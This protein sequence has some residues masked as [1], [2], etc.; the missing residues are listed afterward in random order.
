M[1]TATSPSAGT[2]A[3]A[4]VALL[5]PCRRPRRSR[6]GAAR[7]SA[8]TRREPSPRSRSAHASPRGGRPSRQCPLTTS[9]ASAPI[10]S[11]RP[12]DHRPLGEP[13]AAAAADAVD[14]GTDHAP[15]VCPEA[16]PMEPHGL[17]RGSPEP[18]A[19]ADFACSTKGGR[20]GAPRGAVVGRG[21]QAALAPLRGCGGQTY[22]P[23]LRGP[24][25]PR[26]RP[27]AGH[28]AP[29]RAAGGRPR[30]STPPGP[31][32][33][34][35]HPREDPRLARAPACATVARFAVDR[36]CR[37]PE[38]LPGHRIDAGPDHDLSGD[39]GDRG[40]DDVGDGLWL[41]DHDHV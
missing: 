21:A 15:E 30:R 7:R 28:R 14:T 12:G 3:P 34:R 6:R 26:Y 36:L 20:A 11:W 33:A 22:S 35:R 16:L 39:L 27:V 38:C 25:G 17:L 41:G 31:D 18:G 5:V 13:D 9:L 8:L 1:T 40:L 19:S 2:Y 24:P 10:P 4:P 23:R 37:T 32:P 29:T